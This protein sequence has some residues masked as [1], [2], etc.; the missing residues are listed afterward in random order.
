MRRFSLIIA[1][2]LS[3][4]T[5]MAYAA[6]THS[7]WNGWLS[8]LFSWHVSLPGH[9]GDIFDARKDNLDSGS[10]ERD[11][12]L[13]ERRSVL[14]NIAASTSA[15][16]F[17][18]STSPSTLSAALFEKK[19]ATIVAE[20]SIAAKGLETSKADLTD[21]IVRGAASGDD[22]GAAQNALAQADQDIAAA[23]DAISALSAYEPI[24]SSTSSMVD[25]TIPQSDLDD[26]ISAIQTARD[27]L[28]SAIQLAG[29]STKAPSEQ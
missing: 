5:S 11:Q 13:N 6:G 26:A 1:I 17:S 3:I 25:L 28:Q 4:P 15:G 21:F 7:G 16:Y 10:M 24:A 9:L 29:E 18:A 22:M 12:L 20:L 14:G 27:D 2:A 8:G 23:N 19:R